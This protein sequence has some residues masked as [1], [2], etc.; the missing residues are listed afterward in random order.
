MP[1]GVRVR[2]LS[3]MR[4]SQRA[5]RASASITLVLSQRAK[6]LRSS[7]R[8][9][10]DMSVGEPDFPAPPV[11]QEAAV[12]KVRSGDVR[13][14]PAAGTPEL[15]AAVARHLSDTRGVPFAAEQVWIGHSAKHA[16]STAC[17]A[18]FDPGDRLLLPQ[19][20]WL[21]YDEMALIAGLEPVPVAPPP[22]VDGGSTTGGPDLDALERE[23]ARGARALWI[24]TPSNPTGYVWSRDEI[25][26]AVEIAVRHDLVILSDEIYRRLVYGER[27]FCS[28]VEVDPRALERTVIVDGASKAFC[29]TGYRIGFA[30][31]PKEAIV[32]LT[33]IGSQMAGSPNAI[34]QA[35]YLAALASEPPEVERM[36]ATYRERRDRLTEGLREL[37][38]AFPTPHGAFYV[39][40]DVTP[41]LAGA[42]D[43]QQLCADLL[44][45]EALVL[46]PGSAFGAPRHV[47]LSYVLSDERIASALERLR[48]F[49]ERRG[50]LSGTAC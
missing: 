39:L 24:N 48:R 8:D 44:E 19:P 30:A 49:A 14:T 32:A 21:S 31:G 46:V 37:G 50:L 47:R 45:E 15:R 26:G 13:Y 41:W 25:A 2:I 42:A 6:E 9:V 40:P 10:V 35:A 7:G 29:M 17:L 20:G 27:P 23:A 12:A 18:L 3:G 43:A 22:A 28:P 11:V 5:E 38:L 33:K 1:S 4:V 34:S 16:L 36:V